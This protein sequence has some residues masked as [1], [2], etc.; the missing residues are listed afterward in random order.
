MLCWRVGDLDAVA[1]CDALDDLRQLVLTFQPV[2]GLGGGHHELEHHQP[3]RVLRQRA[4]GPHRAVPDGGKHALDRVGRAQVIPVLG[5]KVVEGQ[6]GVAVLEQ[7]GDRLLVFGPVLLGEALD[8]CR[9]GGMGGGGPFGG[10]GGGPF[11]MFIL[12]FSQSCQGRMLISNTRRRTLR[13]PRIR[14]QHGRRS[15]CPRSPIWRRRT[16]T[17]TSTTCRPFILVIVIY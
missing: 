16:T 11:G 9:G 7:A 6:Q 13:R 17:T 10:M 15:W 14:F 1:E 5:R 3:G 2:P 12:S 8:R 4:L